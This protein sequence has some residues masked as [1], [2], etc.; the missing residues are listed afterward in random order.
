MKSVRP[1]IILFLLTNI[2]IGYVTPVMFSFKSN[3]FPIYYYVLRAVLILIALACL[4]AMIQP[5]IRRQKSG[6]KKRGASWAV[7]AMLLIVF[8]MAELFL[9]FYPET[10]GKNDTYCSKTWQYYYWKL[11]YQ[12]FRDK[13][14]RDLSAERKPA[15][16]FAGDSYTEGHGIKNPEDRVSD[17]IR[18]Q[19]PD[20]TIYNVGK[21]GMNILDEIDLITHMPVT[22]EIIVL[23]TCSNDWDYLQERLSVVR[24]SSGMLHAAAD[25]AWL[26]KYYIV[27]DYL[28]S[29]WGN[30]VQ[31]LF[32]QR[33][34]DSSVE[35]LYAAFRLS[36][37]NYT[38]SRQVVEVFRHC[39]QYTRLPQDSV[40]HVLFDMFKEHNPSL[41]VMADTALF[42][43]YL[44][45][46]VYLDGFCK[47]RNIHLLI[48]PYPEMDK[49]SMAVSAG[50]INKYLCGLMRARNLD[51]LDIYPALKKAEL[52]SYTVNRYDN[53]INEAASR[54]VAAEIA[55]YCKPY[56]DN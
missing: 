30:L 52:P 3:F 21:N 5:V 11:N 4:P 50:Y 17:I 19:F 6:D 29:K 27:F 34:D 48:V 42:A 55:K 7:L 53:H 28:A 45:K 14:F 23:Q 36:P 26:T 10:N 9:T 25:G 8:Y 32:E 41:R 33:L 46:L 24:S 39:M 43:D 37:E 44:D 18:R 12:G 54:V 1:Y 13:D 38:D 20:Y 22:P 35:K 51:C 47:Q 2:A 56:F 15:M 16:V 40:P 49:F 31:R